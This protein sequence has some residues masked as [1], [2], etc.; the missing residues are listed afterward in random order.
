[1]NM[2]VWLGS[3]L[4]EGGMGETTISLRYDEGFSPH[5]DEWWKTEFELTFKQIVLGQLAAASNHC[6]LV[7]LGHIN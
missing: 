7:G 4:R 3:V 5:Y 2:N 6:N 1:M